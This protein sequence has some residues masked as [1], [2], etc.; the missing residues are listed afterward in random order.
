M[1][2]SHEV[3]KSIWALKP[4]TRSGDKRSFCITGT[5]YIL[6]SA[7]SNHMIDAQQMT[8]SFEINRIDAIINAQLRLTGEPDTVVHNVQVYPVATF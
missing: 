2:N 4:F 6:F 1:E 7:Y 5:R 3:Q 8:F